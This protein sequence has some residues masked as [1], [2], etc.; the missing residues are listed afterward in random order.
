M[1]LSCTLPK[2]LKLKKQACTIL[3]STLPF[4]VTLTF[5]TS[6]LEVKVEFS[7]FL[8]CPDSVYLGTNLKYDIIQMI[9]IYIYIHFY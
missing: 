2:N 7:N 3:P 6:P 9:Y 1:Y 5:F 4:A 8:S